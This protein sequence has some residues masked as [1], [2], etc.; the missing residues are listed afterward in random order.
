MSIVDEIMKQK[1]NIINVVGF[2]IVLGLV[3][4]TC[5]E[6]YLAYADTPNHLTN[7]IFLIVIPF[8][9]VICYLI[10]L[11]VDQKTEL[12]FFYFAG[13]LVFFFVI[14]YFV[15]EYLP[16]I[17]YSVIVHY[18]LMIISIFLGLALIYWIFIKKINNS[19]T[20]EGFIMNMIFYIPCMITDAIQYMTNDIFNTSTQITILFA[21]EIICILLYVYGL[22][23]LD[24]SIYKDGILVLNLPVFLNVQQDIGAAL[25]AGNYTKQP[26][27]YYSPY[28]GFPGNIVGFPQGPT[29]YRRNYAVSV[30][31][32]MNTMPNT[33]LGYAKESDVFYYGSTGSFHPKI[34]YS[35]QTG[36]SEYNL[37]YSGNT[38]THQI[39]MPGQKWNNVVFNYKED[40]VDVFVNGELTLSHTFTTDLPEYKNGDIFSVGHSYTDTEHSNK[41]VFNAKSLYGAVC[42]VAYYVRPLTLS[43][44]V[45]NYNVLSIRNPP[46]LDN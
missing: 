35:N 26:A 16:S 1:Q 24:H 38:S 42:S 21:I 10:H 45:R 40:G 32:Y 2:F 44:I 5:H 14:F 25:I 28:P 3:Y 22:P 6:L 36:V 34:T 30:W 33:T 37:Y 17:N 46:I 11:L 27:P 39:E 41:E 20:W 43:E 29:S 4:F 19:D 9:I 23:A 12:Q 15:V 31:V 18:V 8:L 7:Y 13:I